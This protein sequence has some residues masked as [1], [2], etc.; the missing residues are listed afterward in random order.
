MPNR[1]ELAQI[2]ITA[3][4]NG[5]T[6]VF[7]ACDRRDRDHHYPIPVFPGTDPRDVIRT[8]RDPLLYCLALQH[9]NLPLR[10]QLTE[11]RAWHPEPAPGVS[12]ADLAR[13]AP[14]N[15]ADRRVGVPPPAS[16]AQDID[17]YAALTALASSDGRPSAAAVQRARWV[18]VEQLEAARHEVDLARSW[19]F[20][21]SNTSA[22]YSHYEGARGKLTNLARAA[23][24]QGR[25]GPY[26]VRRIT[27][28][29]RNDV[30]PLP[31][32]R[33]ATAHDAPVAV[34]TGIGD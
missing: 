29:S 7:V 33:S 1:Y 12:V 18:T 23:Y 16:V 17:T 10:D 9:M 27:G 14:P 4:H 8:S 30:A 34:S 13:L 19:T 28:F 3:K 11:H 24:E 15:P 20:S 6:H 32:A 31:Q 2:A 26:N 25:I 5:A 22:E 21:P